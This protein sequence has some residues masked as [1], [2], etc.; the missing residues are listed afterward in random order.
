MICHHQIGIHFW[1]HY[2]F[3]IEL[4]R[5][6]GKTLVVQVNR[7]VK[8]DI[9][10]LVGKPQLASVWCMSNELKGLTFP[11]QQYDRWQ[12]HLRCYRLFITGQV[13]EVDY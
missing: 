6:I 12:D 13:P 7:L 9:R 8:L 10:L 4:P 3:Y 2:L 11:S 1:T 5:P